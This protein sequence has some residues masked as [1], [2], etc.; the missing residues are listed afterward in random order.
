[1]TSDRVERRAGIAGSVSSNRR[2]GIVPPGPL[3]RL[4]A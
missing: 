4:F 3:Q 2:V 1:M